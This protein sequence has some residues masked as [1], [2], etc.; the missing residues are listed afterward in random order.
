M[1]IR[2]LALATTCLAMPLYA[3]TPVAAPTAGAPAAF[4]DPKAAQLEP[5]EGRRVAESLAADLAEAFV[6]PSQGAQYAAML[7]K[8]AAAGRYDK[9]ARGD[10]AD[11]VT[12]DLMAVHKDGHLHLEVNRPIQARGAG[13]NVLSGFGAPPPLI[14][15]SKW[16]A[17]GVAYI[18]TTRFMGTDAELADIAAFMRE[19][20]DA[21]TIIFDL[22]NN[23]GGG[24]AEMNVIFPYLF[25]AK[26]PLVE[27]EM[28]R[29][30]FDKV[31][32]PFDDSPTLTRDDAGVM[33]RMIHS[34]LPGPDTPLRK[35]KVYL[36]TSNATASAAE[37]FALAMKSTGRGTLIGEPTMGA[38]H[39]GAPDKVGEHFTAFLP[40]GRTF[41]L[42]T[43]KD[44]E[45]D[46]I[47]PDI[48]A[49]P[50]TALVVALEK[51]GIDHAEAVRLDSLEV[52]SEP[53]HKTQLRSR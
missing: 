26:T 17:P 19:H 40:V 52:P 53:V 14:Q 28:S 47:A 42:K 29:S 39:F 50:V 11:L 5:G 9:G 12:S 31:G 16:I 33:V 32:S 30:I 25:A 13:G 41:D 6:I 24:L 36:L 51:A 38:N 37:H 44:W 18:R 46:G 10:F 23:H 2:L 48:A 27:L 34:A 3:A 22:R 45:G 1:R 15:A 43:G 20:Q 8:N 4:S 7:R 35:A 49:N 21:S